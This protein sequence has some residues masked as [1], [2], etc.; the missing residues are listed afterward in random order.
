MVTSADGGWGSQE[1]DGSWNGM[2]GMIE[3]G[4]VTVAVSSFFATKDRS[5]VVDFSATLDYAE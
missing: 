5:E 4:E 1:V 3:R 2:V